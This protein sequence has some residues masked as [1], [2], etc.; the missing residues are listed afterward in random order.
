MASKGFYS[1]M[2]EQKYLKIIRWSIFGCAFVPLVFYGQFLSIFNFPKLA[3]FRSIVEI[4]LIFYIL[5]IIGNKKYRPN[6]KNPL[7]LAVTVFTGLYII[8]SITGINF[9]RS[10]W[11]TLE[12]MGG[13]FS[14][15]HYWIFFVVLISV[16]RSREDWMK[17][18]KFSVI[19]GFL[20][21][22]FGFGQK[23]HLSDFF[24]GWQHGSRIIS[25]AGNAALYAG[26]LIFIIFL[27]LYLLIHNTNPTNRNT[28][29]TNNSWRLRY[30]HAFYILV[31]VLGTVSLFMTAVRGS[32][33]SFGMALFLLAIFIVV[34]SKNEKLKYF[35]IGFLI[36]L[37]LVVG[38]LWISKDQ[39][40]VKNTDYL[41]RI[42]DISLEVRTVQTRFSGWTAAWQGWKERF[43]LG[44]GP[45]NFKVLFAK[46]F[47]PMHYQGHGS[48][49]VWDRA[50]NT[51]LNIAA[52]MG[53]VGLL[54][55][56]SIFVVLLWRLVGLFK[57]NRSGTNPARSGINPAK[58]GINNRRRISVGV[59]GAMF[60]AYIGHNLFIFDSFNTYLLLF[61]TLGYISYKYRSHYTPNT[62]PLSVGAG[63]KRRNKGD[64]KA[65]IKE[66]KILTLRRVA[67]IILTPIVLLTIW[68]TAVIPAKANYAATRGIIYGRSDKH[69]ATAFNY[70]RKSLNYNP[71]QGHYVIRHHL[72]RVVF[73]IFSKTDDPRKFGVTIDD[74]QFALDEVYKNIEKYPRDYNSY[75]YGARLNEF[76]SRVEQEEN[77][78]KAKQRL[79][80]A[81][82]LLKRAIELNDT[83]PYIYFELGQVKIFQN[84]F[85]ES[86]KY[87]DQGL[88]LNP[89]V[90]LGYWYK[91]RAYLLLGQEEKA[92]KLIKLA[93]EKG[94]TKTVED[95]RKLIQL[96]IE[97]KNYPK[98]IEL[99]KEAIKIQ[100]QNAQFY[101]SLA[102]AYQE[103]G[104]IDKAIEAARKVGELDPSKKAEA[105]AWIET[106]KQ[107][108]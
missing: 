1:Y 41:N 45:E 6:F 50:H 96:Y 9:Y 47:N 40:W 43:I 66:G 87:F 97:E 75:L 79:E 7:L 105:E 26:Y 70:F 29:A 39:P 89:D 5:L 63:V 68:K 3:V 77:P 58:N 21:I 56:L 51:P 33:L 71:V 64:L 44:W 48:E 93:Y 94:Y 80:E 42:T 104:Q 57:R 67:A 30:W 15:V 18:L 86:I 37:I 10:F 22:L 92:E 60:I 84:K 20:A 52:T 76:I 53:I 25:T 38:T 101:A 99:Y 8:T 12:R 90:A 24:V 106:L 36:I 88:E 4:M 62:T 2:S 14:F 34:K 32:I 27:A 49:V 91:G 17:L 95:I 19:A 69:L 28:N 16:F 103:N 13:V 85:E 81:E 31:I 59:L 72:A 74:M 55:Y 107:S 35:G 98:I 11:G 100:P 46:Y 102:K 23:F 73:R 83:Y 108:N 82:R 61:I 65:S 78:Q 54:S